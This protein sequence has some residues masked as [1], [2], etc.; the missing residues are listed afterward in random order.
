MIWYLTTVFPIH[1]RKLNSLYEQILSLHVDCLDQKILSE[2]RSNPAPTKR[3]WTILTLI[4]FNSGLNCLSGTWPLKLGHFE[5][6]YDR[7]Q[8]KMARRFGLDSKGKSYEFLQSTFRLC[9]TR[10]AI[11][12]FFQWRKLLRRWSIFKSNLSWLQSRYWGW[13]VRQTPFYLACDTWK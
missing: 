6:E 12:I 11:E 1:I 7:I 2:I 10:N 9:E 8:E 5:N 13:Y 3:L 4:H